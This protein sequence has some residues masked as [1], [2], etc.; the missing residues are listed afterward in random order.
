[1][2]AV[3]SVVPSPAAPWLRTETA[4]RP[5]TVSR[6]SWMSPAEMPPATPVG[7]RA[8]S[9]ARVLAVI[10]PLPRPP[11]DGR[12]G[13]GQGRDRDVAARDDVGRVQVELLAARAGGPLVDDRRPVRLEQPEEG[14][15]PGGVRRR[16]EERRVG[17]AGT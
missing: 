5:S 14:G 3:S 7:I 17:K 1:M 13:D 4:P 2:A 16:S 12:L 6:K 8:L 11:S 9:S 10:G 15:R